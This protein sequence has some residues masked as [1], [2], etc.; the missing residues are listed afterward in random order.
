M[1]PNRL[2]S[3]DWSRRFKEQPHALVGRDYTRLSS[4]RLVTLAT[5]TSADRLHHLPDALS[6]WGTGPASVAIFAPD[7]EFDLAETFLTWMGR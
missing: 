1:P 5:Q 7:V 6:A 4:R 2:G 3:F